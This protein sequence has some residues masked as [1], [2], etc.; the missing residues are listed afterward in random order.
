ML[1]LNRSRLFN[2]PCDFDC[3]AEIQT[4]VPQS[5]IYTAFIADRTDSDS[6][7]SELLGMTTDSAQHADA[8]IPTTN[9]VQ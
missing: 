1:F 2:S 8:C 9:P 7:V 4:A 5:E 3:S 6:I